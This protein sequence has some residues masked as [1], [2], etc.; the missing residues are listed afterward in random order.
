MNELMKDS[1]RS[2]Q[3][4][5]EPLNNYVMIDK[6]ELSSIGKFQKV[7]GLKGE[8]NAVFEIN[9]DYLLN[10][11]PVIVEVDGL[12]VPFFITSIRP[13]GS[14]SYLIKLDGIESEKDASAFV[15][16]EL[17]SLSSD[18]KESGED[19]FEFRNSFEGFSIIDS[20]SNKSVGTVIDIDD[21]TSNIL[22]IVDCGEEMPVYIPF[23][24]DLI[25][26]IN[27]NEK[28]IIMNLPEGLLD[29]N[30]K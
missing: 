15:N 17:F 13:K 20:G 11:V 29:I 14:T 2:G 26:E 23:S 10:D 25:Q 21:A 24:E 4:S 30:R 6:N 18:L 5:S 7:H 9:P 3:I 22:L 8:L 27:E 19:Y 1:I 16:K 12:M 28:L